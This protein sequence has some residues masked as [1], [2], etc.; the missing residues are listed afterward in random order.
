MQTEIQVVLT[1][2][3]GELADPTTLISG[4]LTQLAP[5]IGTPVVPPDT[6]DA[7]LAALL[8]D[9]Q[10]RERERCAAI[11]TKALNA[12]ARYDDSVRIPVYR[13]LQEITQ[14]T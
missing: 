11:V 2:S 5:L 12:M 10:Q 1:L 4:L 8:A 3:R 13:A 14:G 7:Q 9:T 6:T